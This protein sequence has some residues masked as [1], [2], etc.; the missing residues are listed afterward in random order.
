MVG[1]LDLGITASLRELCLLS[2]PG[3]FVINVL[4]SQHHPINYFVLIIIDS[5][6]KT[7]VYVCSATT[8]HVQV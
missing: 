6:T 8:V 7:C 1:L 4:A 3:T 2:T 5:S